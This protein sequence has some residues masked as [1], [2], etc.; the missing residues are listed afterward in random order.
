MH[1]NTTVDSTK[2]Q[3]YELIVVKGCISFDVHFPQS[4]L[5]LKSSK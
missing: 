5:E 3:F 4:L 1:T 2:T